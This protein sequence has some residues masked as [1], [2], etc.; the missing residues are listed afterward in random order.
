MCT[1]WTEGEN[2]RPTFLNTP[3]QHSNFSSPEQRTNKNTG[4]GGK[5]EIK[6]TEKAG[7]DEGSGVYEAVGCANVLCAV[8]CASFTCVDN[9]ERK[10]EKY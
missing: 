4:E 8:D 7:R 5:Q 3:D 9:K 10:A 1:D 6:R 2:K